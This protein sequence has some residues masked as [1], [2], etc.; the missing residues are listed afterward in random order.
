MSNRIYGPSSHTED[1]D[2]YKHGGLHPLVIGDSIHDGR[3]RIIHKLGSGSFSTVWL[4]RDTLSNKYVSLKVLDASTPL[5]SK[6]LRILHHIAASSLE[7]PGR[8]YVTHLLDNFVIEGPNGQHRCLVTEAAGQRLSRKPE[9]KVGSLDQARR[10]GLQI[11][12]ALGFLHA[13]EIAHGDCYTSNILTRLQNFDDWSEEDIY[14]TMGQPVKHMVWRLDGDPRGDNAPEYTVQ[15]GN[16]AALDARLATDRIVLVD[17][18]EA[19]Y[20]EERPKKIV[21]PA[22]FASPEIVFGTE[23]TPAHDQWAFACILYEIAAD[24][25]LFKMIFGWFNDTLK[26]QVAM[27]GKPPQDAWE[28]WDGRTK[29]FHHDGTPKEAEGRRLT[30]RPLT[31]KQRVRNISKPLAERNYGSPSELNEPLSEELQGLYDLLRGLLVYDPTSRSSF[32]EVQAHSFFAQGCPT[33]L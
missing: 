31:L 12:Q 29:Y 1:P 33:I 9:S 15:V 8:Q 22:P 16:V 27:L 6:E 32:D 30:V 4:A 24:H 7:H 2:R 18:G 14:E 25:S 20:H 26:D 21:T 23:I 28:R 11:A 13:I 3:Y 17:F 5:G 10:T 19:F